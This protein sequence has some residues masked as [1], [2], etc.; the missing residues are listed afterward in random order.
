M[1][2]VHKFDHINTY[3]H[4]QYMYVQKPFIFY[5]FHHCLVEHVIQMSFKLYNRT[6]K[7]PSDST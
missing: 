5:C 6:D 2:N 4:T 3:S 7:I 1:S